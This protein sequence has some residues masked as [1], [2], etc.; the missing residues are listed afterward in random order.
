MLFTEL[1]YVVV[2]LYHAIYLAGIRAM[3]DYMIL[4]SCVPCSGSI[5]RYLLSWYTL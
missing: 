2:D 3:A 1:A 4:L 5:S